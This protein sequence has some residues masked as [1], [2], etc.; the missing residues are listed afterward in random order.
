MTERTTL[1]LT[2][3][4]VWDRQR[5]QSEYIPEAYERDGFIHCTDGDENLLSVATLFYSN[6][7]RDFVV[8]TL[9]VDKIRSEVKYEDPDR[10]YPHIYGPL[11]TDAV[12]GIKA[13]ERSADGQF[14]RIV[15][16]E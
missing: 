6:D 15:T 16:A 2:P 7:A 12:I 9:A 3:K 1:H 10:I 8:L 4:D 13:I 14:D 5:N 11:N